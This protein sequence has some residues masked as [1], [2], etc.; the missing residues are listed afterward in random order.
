M[1]SN[2]TANF[3]HETIT[4]GTGKRITRYA[5]GTVFFHWQR[6]KPKGI[7][8]SQS[9]RWQSDGDPGPWNWQLIP[10]PPAPPVA[11]VSM[12]NADYQQGG[13]WQFRAAERPNGRVSPDWQYGQV[14]FPDGM[15][16]LGGRNSGDLTKAF[17]IARTA[18]LAL[19]LIRA[20]RPWPSYAI[21]S[22]ADVEGQQRGHA[23]NPSGAGR[24]SLM[25]VDGLTPDKSY[26]IDL[27]IHTSPMLGE[28]EPLK[29][30]RV[31]VQ[32]PPLMAMP[33]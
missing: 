26:L 23:D 22:T 7:Y 30:D 31:Q 15:Q 33:D 12:I 13:M 10:T 29:T 8:V 4:G 3:R 21:Q 14:F 19:V 32:A 20:D 5:N 24:Y 1:F 27:T 16:T 9:R 6:A 25:K 2:L 18:T 17:L 28:T 11:K